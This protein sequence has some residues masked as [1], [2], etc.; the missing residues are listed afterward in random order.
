MKIPKINSVKPDKDYMLR[1]E[2][3]SG[4]AVLYDVSEDIDSIPAFEPLRS[5]PGLFDQVQLDQSRTIV[6]WNDV[7][8]LPSDTILEFGKPVR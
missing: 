8:D 7:I 3:D 2:F 5:A 1:V 6:V 4:E